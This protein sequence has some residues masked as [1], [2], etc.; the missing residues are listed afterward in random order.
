MTMRFW[1][2]ILCTGILLST[3]GC[4]PTRYKVILETELEKNFPDKDVSQYITQDEI[5]N[6]LSMQD[7]SVFV[8]EL[9]NLVRV[10]CFAPYRYSNPMG[11]DVM[12]NFS[13]I[14]FRITKILLFTKYQEEIVNVYTEINKEPNYEYVASIAI[15]YN[16][17]YKMIMLVRNKI[18]ENTLIDFIDSLPNEKQYILAQYK[19]MRQLST[20]VDHKSF[21]NAYMNINRDNYE[22]ILNKS[23]TF[24]VHNDPEIL[25]KSIEGFSYY[26]KLLSLKDEM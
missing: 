15:D 19:V 16:Y 1:I 2:S 11:Y 25:N 14:Y 23:Q 24:L 18:R 9:L 17:Y 22:E 5:K 12:Y 21:Y 6:L 26:Y 8:Y 3:V 13:D 7:D 20:K 10:K 4:L